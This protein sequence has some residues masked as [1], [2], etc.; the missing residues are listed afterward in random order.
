M[1]AMT[2][3]LRYIPVEQAGKEKNVDGSELVKLIRRKNP[4]FRASPESPKP[5]RMGLVA[6][7]EIEGVTMD[8]KVHSQS[9]SLLVLVEPQIWV[10]RGEED[11]EN[12]RSL[13]QTLSAIYS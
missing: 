1:Q 2:A 11:E 3:E 4:T 9:T 13:Q 7:L 8:E 10:N 6:E 12:P 5:T